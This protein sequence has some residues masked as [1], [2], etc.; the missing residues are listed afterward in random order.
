MGYFLRRAMS[1]RQMV[2][3][4]EKER[5][6]LL[7]KARQTLIDAGSFEERYEL[8]LGNFA[9]FELYC[10]ETALR[11]NLELDFRY[12]KFASVFSEAN[13]HA[14]NFLA[15]TRQYAD[16]VVRD[17]KH[18][19]LSEPFDVLARRL[20]NQAHEKALAY[21]FVYE[22]RN[23][24]QHRATAVHGSKGRNGNDAWLEGTMLYCQKKHLVADKGKFK[25]KVLDELDDEIDLLA[26]FRDYMASVSRVQ[27]PLRKQIKQA[28][29]DARE[30]IQE[31][32][33]EFSEAQVNEDKRSKPATGLTAVKGEIDAYTDPVTLM[34]DW[35]DARVVLAEKNSRPITVPKA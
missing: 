16:Q 25:Q 2:I 6:E 27:L 30:V 22:L 11:S 12:E 13:R 4:I 31:A 28:C 8:L 33:V 20:L 18:L 1:G 32:C 17:F 14:I 15:T 9:A 19:E 10:A 34:L 21:R 26:M 5:Y 35:D 3:P 7:A 24:V 29:I 23:F